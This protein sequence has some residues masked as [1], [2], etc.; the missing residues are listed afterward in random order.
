MS[1]TAYLLGDIGSLRVRIDIKRLIDENNVLKN[2]STPN[3]T[4]EIYFVFELISH[5]HIDSPK[6]YS[7]TYPQKL[8]LNEVILFD[9]VY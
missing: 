4:N 9:W 6:K 5:N 3:S 1:N 2:Q 7:K 8:E